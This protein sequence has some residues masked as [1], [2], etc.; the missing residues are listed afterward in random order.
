MEIASAFGPDLDDPSWRSTDA[1][2]DQ[3]PA[4]RASWET[5]L[6]FHSQSGVSMAGSS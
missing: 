3:G 1:R 5:G 2:I 4:V 6:G